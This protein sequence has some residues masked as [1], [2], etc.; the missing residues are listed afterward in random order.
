M[1]REYDFS[2]E[3]LML[4]ASSACLDFIPAATTFHRMEISALEFNEKVPTRFAD[5]VA[6]ED[7]NEFRLETCHAISTCKSLRRQCSRAAGAITAFSVAILIAGLFYPLANFVD[8]LLF[9][10]C[11]VCIVLFFHLYVPLRK[12]MRA[13]PMEGARLI[14]WGTFF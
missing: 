3:M 7:W 13:V 1:F 4:F 10:L 6:P 8:F 14:F 9:A 12:A 11:I 2:L 5:V